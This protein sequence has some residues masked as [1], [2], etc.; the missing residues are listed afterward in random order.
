MRAVVADGTGLV[1]LLDGDAGALAEAPADEA[2]DLME[3][4]ETVPAA[5]VLDGPVTQRLL[6]V[7]AQRGVAQVVGATEGA[8][9]KRPTNVR[10]RSVDDF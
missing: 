10:I 5:V 4:A 8:F 9:V 1:R 6:D 3:S 7:A 2:F